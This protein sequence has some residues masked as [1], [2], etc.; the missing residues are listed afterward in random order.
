MAVLSEFRQSPCLGVILTGGVFQAEAR[1]LR[2][3]T[4]ARLGKFP[5]EIPLPA[6]LRRDRDDAFKRGPKDPN[7]TTTGAL[8]GCNFVIKVTGSYS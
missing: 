3:Q 8:H 5:R 4:A 7:C 6:E 1:I 2:A